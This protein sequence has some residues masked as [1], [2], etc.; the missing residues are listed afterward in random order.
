MHKSCSTLIF[1]WGNPSRGDDAIGPTI[2]D[3]LQQENLQSVEL[4]TDFQLQIEHALDLE[5]RQRILFVD[6]SISAAA[7]FE[8]HRLK[9]TE[10]ETYTTHAM[11]PESLLYVY[12]KVNRQ[13]VMPAYMLA[14]RG[15]EFEL[16][17][18]LSGKAKANLSQALEFIKRLVSST[19]DWDRKASMLVR[20]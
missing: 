15:Y 2:Y 8:F 14:I 5:N 17:R 10:D 20:E 6:A 18:P 9:A 12:N 4:L 16:G 11:S 19:E 1:T 13:P 7:P 3:R